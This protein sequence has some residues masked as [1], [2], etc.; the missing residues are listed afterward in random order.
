MIASESGRLISRVPLQHQFTIG[1]IADAGAPERLLNAMFATSAWTA[2]WL[3]LAFKVTIKEVVPVKVPSLFHNS[4]PNDEV[5]AE[6]KVIAP[7]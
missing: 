1:F 3:A 4:C 5:D 7:T 2:D 6:K